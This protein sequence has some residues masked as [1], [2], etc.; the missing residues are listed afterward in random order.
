L[1]KQG[2][3]I[4]AELVEVKNRYGEKCHIKR[5]SFGGNDYARLENNETRI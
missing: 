4:V 3:D 2:F 1:R 5:Y